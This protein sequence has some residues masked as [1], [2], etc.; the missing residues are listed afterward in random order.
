MGSGAVVFS[1]QVRKRRFRVTGFRNLCCL[2]LCFCEK[3]QISWQ[4]DCRQWG[5]GRAEAKVSL[6]TRSKWWVAACFDRQ[7]HSN[8]PVQWLA[9]TARS[10]IAD[11]PGA[12]R[13]GADFACCQR[14][15]SPVQKTSLGYSKLSVGVNV[16]MNVCLSLYVSPVM[17][18]RFIQCQPRHRPITAGI[19]S[20]T[21]LTVKSSSVDGWMFA[22][23]WYA[24]QFTETRVQ[25][26]KVW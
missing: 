26:V 7:Y 1:G 19:G 3:R 11:L 4:W 10:W 20:S 22:V 14:G 18:W 21:I 13:L 16:S 23:W 8:T 6:K 17:N 2:P 24:K 15:F 25:A 9:P 12:G 5:M